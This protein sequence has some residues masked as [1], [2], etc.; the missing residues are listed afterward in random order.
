MS[1]SDPLIKLIKNHIYNLTISQPVTDAH[2]SLR[3]FCELLE[4]VFRKGLRPNTS[5][6]DFTH[7]DY[8][9]WL[10]NLSHGITERTVRLHPLFDV[11]I[12]QVKL[13]TK[14][15]SAQGR[16][17]LFLR[18][19]L[20]N[21]LLHNTIDALLKNSYFLFTWYDPEKSFFADDI[22]SEILLSLLLQVSELNFQ[23]C[24]KNNS[25]LDET[26]LIPSYR[27]LQLVPCIDLG[28]QL[29]HINGRVVVVSLN[30]RGVAADGKEI[31]VGDVLDEMYE[32][33]LRNIV[34]GT[35]PKLMRKHR[36]T[37]VN[38]AVVKFRG[39]D[40][41]TFPPLVQLRKF[42]KKEGCTFDELPPEKPKTS[43]KKPPHA[44]LPEDGEEEVPVHDDNEK[45]EYKVQYIG[46]TVIG[47]DGGVHQVEPAIRRLVNAEEKDSMEVNF[48]LGETDVF[49]R[50]IN[51][52]EV[53]FRVSYTEISACGRRTD[54]MQYFAYLAGET[55]C[56]LAKEFVAYVYKA[57]TDE[58]AKTI[59][60]SIAQGFDRTHWFV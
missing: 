48:A 38:L 14:V 35:I 42:L 57:N 20:Q 44:L 60:C 34:K 51:S 31:E 39:D 19:S 32:K 27:Q 7:K 45:V 37:P 47:Q 46:K 36:D 23:L 9:N 30:E 29:H 6:F 1:V 10:E 22:L 59:I 3:P 8:W 12:S 54:S 43:T 2:S 18:L 5:L 26:W 41:S 13:S 49:V 21:K 15:T 4:I 24:I 33:P 50:K 25:F 40:G 58:E 17:R 56:T 52:D 55:T 53:L 16:G 11:A 28:L